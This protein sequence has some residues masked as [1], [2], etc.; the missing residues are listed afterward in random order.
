[1]GKFEDS[2]A[3]L[4]TDFNSSLKIFEELPDR[5][6]ILAMLYCRFE[7]PEIIEL[8]LEMCESPIEKIFLLAFEI[9]NKHKKTDIFISPQVE[10]VGTKKD[11]I[12]DFTIEYDEICNPDFKKDFA[13]II[14]CDGYDFHQ[15]T[16]KQVEYDNN[17]EYDLKMIGYQIIRFSG[18]EIYNNPLK[19]ALKVFDYIDKKAYDN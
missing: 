14:E 1:M 16:K 5:A 8:N 12:A 19:C 10:I 17:R 7:L 13:L 18:S 2:E 6:K 4:Y 9:V 15:K 3:M 11:Y